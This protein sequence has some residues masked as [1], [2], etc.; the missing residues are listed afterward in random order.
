ME[1]N[2]GNVE[3]S[4][5]VIGLYGIS[6][7]GKSYCLALL[8]KERPEWR[9]ID[10]SQVMEGVLRDRGYDGIESFKGLAKDDATTVRQE[11]LRRIQAFAGVTVVAGHGSFPKRSDSMTTLEFDDVFTK[12][13]GETYNAIL[14]LDVDADAVYKHRSDDSSRIRP[15]YDTA[16]LERWIC[17]EEELLKNKCKEHGILFE[18]VRPVDVVKCI[19]E[20]VVHPWVESVLQRSKAALEQAVARVPAADV[21]L[22]I[23]GDRTFTPADT[24]RAFLMQPVPRTV[25]RAPLPALSTTLSS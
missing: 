5:V 4:K 22:M 21:Y 12:E 20:R 13:D 15:A 16:C 10:G 14:Y 9:C 2:G 19:V 3:P 8:R 6:G 24:G 25:G 18:L 1:G 7:A 11:A 17:H 23:D